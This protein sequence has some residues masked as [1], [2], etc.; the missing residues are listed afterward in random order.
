MP[1][2]GNSN[3]PPPFHDASNNADVILRSS[4]NINFYCH[5]KVLSK[6]S[7]FFATM[8]SLPQ[9]ETEEL[10]PMGFQSQCAEACRPTLGADVVI[11]PIDVTED[12]RALE[13]LLRAC[14]RITAQIP[15]FDLS[16][17]D[18]RPLIEATRKYEMDDAVIRL[19]LRRLLDLVKHHPLVVYAAACTLDIEYIARC[20]ASTFVRAVLAKHSNGKSRIL[21][22]FFDAYVDDLDDLPAGAY[23]RLLFIC[24]RRVYT[25]DLSSPVCPQ[26]CQPLARMTV[27]PPSL[28]I[29]HPFS[30]PAKGDIIFQT[31][32]GARL[33]VYRQIIILA[34]PILAQ[35]IEGAPAAPLGSHSVVHLPG[36]VDGH[37]FSMLLQFCYPMG[38]PDI[39]DLSEAEHLLELAKHYQ[40]TR[41]AEA[42]R[43]KFR[44]SIGDDP[45]RVFFTAARYGWVE[46]TEEAA[47]HAVYQPRDYY[48]GAMEDVPARI[49]RRLLVFRQR[50]R[51]EIFRFTSHQQQLLHQPGEAMALYW[52]KDDVNPFCIDTGFW[53]QIHKRLY[54][55]ANSRDVFLDLTVNEIVGASLPVSIAR[56]ANSVKTM[57]KSMVV[58][59]IIHHSVDLVG[60]VANALCE[61]SVNDAHDMVNPNSQAVPQIKF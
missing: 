50:C 42:A 14:Y 49:Y 18:V 24:S 2:R 43:R 6:C 55:A 22:C 13:S 40:I 46:E 48:V 34:S 11:M 3:G 35:E 59:D 12:A 39:K 58:R 19:I 30:D 54:K 17:K 53:L 26:F 29:T 21:P 44:E 38:D 33:Y 16:P 61:V 56:R 57:S 45:F 23:F 31:S 47:I 5:K 27:P 20:A 37:S 60:V 8:F 25:F 28:P 41:A 32:C 52:S 15:T 7:P 10:L 36:S 51:K 4:D 1:I 9:T